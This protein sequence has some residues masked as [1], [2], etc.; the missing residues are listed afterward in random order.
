MQGKMLYERVFNNSGKLD[1]DS[2]LKSGIYIVK[3][4]SEGFSFTKKLIV[5]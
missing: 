1:I 2:G 3:A 5:R 4:C